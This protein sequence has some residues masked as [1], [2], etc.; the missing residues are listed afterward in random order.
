VDDGGEG[1]F[2]GAEEGG[3]FPEEGGDDVDAFGGAA[4][5]C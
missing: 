2:G 5:A 3:V 4:R 1:G